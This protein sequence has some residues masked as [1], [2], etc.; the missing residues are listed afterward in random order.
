MNEP[1]RRRVVAG[2][3]ED[4]PATLRFAIDEARLSG[5]DLEVVHCAGHVNY[6]TRI[7]NK[8]YFDNW[9]EAAEHVLDVARKSVAREFDPPRT[10]YR[11]A[12]HAPVDELLQVST[13]AA[14]IIVGSDNPSWFARM[15]APAVART[16]A[17]TAVCPV[18]VVPEHTPTRQS[19]HGV[20]VGIEGDR[21]EE[22]VLRY[23]FEH[24]DYRGREL[25]VVHALPADAWVGEVEAHHAAIAEALAGWSEKYPDVTV[26]QTFVEG[27]PSR[28]C[29]RAT[30]GAELLVIG[31][32]RGNRIPFGFD[33]PLSKSLL[34][35]ATGPV[36]IV[37][38]AFS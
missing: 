6:G 17:F 23:A 38:N 25:R 29:A 7:I 10:H 3:A 24:A 22:H 33:K 20:V 11:M 15:L 8:I 14:E 9:L 32:P 27:D 34:Q 12:D 28:V 35:E 31:Q 16:L 13:E 19:A 4:Q 37:P 5:L 2:L 21:P 36:A 26:T 1:T 18:V 30:M